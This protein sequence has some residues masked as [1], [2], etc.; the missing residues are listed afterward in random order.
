MSP[1]L[2]HTQ[3][4]KK[5]GYSLAVAF[6]FALSAANDDFNK[7]LE[8]STSYAFISPNTLC[9]ALL[10]S[11]LLLVSLSLLLSILLLVSLLL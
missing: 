11:I 1:E 6:D 4:K 8:R 5:P 9:L 2:Q 3:K 7:N 10:L